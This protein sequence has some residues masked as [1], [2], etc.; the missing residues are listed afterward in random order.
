MEDSNSPHCSSWLSWR[1]ISLCSSPRPEVVPAMWSG[2]W[3]P[4]LLTHLPEEAH[5]SGERWY[6]TAGNCLWAPA[7]L[8]LCWGFGF[9]PLNWLLERNKS[10]AA[11]FTP[12]SHHIYGESLFPGFAWNSINSAIQGKLNK[13]VWSEK[14]SKLLCIMFHC[15]LRLLEIK[16]YGW[17]REIA[18]KSE[19][20]Q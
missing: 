14:P 9:V 8:L 12:A 4:S 15:H 19:Q 3:E 6:Q 7:A 5:V 1:E 20:Q 17:Q 18:N 2:W 10:R 11:S 16:S 13:P